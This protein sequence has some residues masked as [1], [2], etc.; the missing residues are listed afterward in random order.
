MNL[1]LCH[2]KVSCLLRPSAG[3]GP[4][5]GVARGMLDHVLFHLEQL[6]FCG[7]ANRMTVLNHRALAPPQAFGLPARTTG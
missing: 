2:V 4:A 3:A 6:S 5:G 7:E 1:G